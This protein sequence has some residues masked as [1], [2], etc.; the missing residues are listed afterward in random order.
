MFFCPPLSGRDEDGVLALARFL[1][2]A[3]RI[4]DHL[5]AFPVV[6]CGR[7]FVRVRSDVSQTPSVRSTVLCVAGATAL[8]QTNEAEC[9]GFALCRAD[10]VAVHSPGHAVGI[11]DNQFELRAD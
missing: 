2:G 10:G 4:L 11:G 3:L 8:G 6:G 7:S 9:D 5:K 1:G